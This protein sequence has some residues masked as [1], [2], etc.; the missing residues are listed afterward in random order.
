MTMTGRAGGGPAAWAKTML[1]IAALLGSVV[2]G[3]G[4]A[5]D[6]DARAQAIAARLRCPVCQNESVADSPSELA[7]QMRAL[8]RDRLARGESEEQI[9]AYFVDRY[10]PWILLEPPRRGLLWVVWLTPAVALAA[11]TAVA[12]AYLRRSMRR[13]SGNAQEPTR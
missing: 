5:Q 10:G 7:A 6:L 2:P 9:V 1:A 13:R 3:M 12:A 8:I 11:G 4:R